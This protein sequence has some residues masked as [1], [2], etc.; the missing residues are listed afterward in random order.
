MRNHLW[1]G[2]LILGLSGCQSLKIL[3]TS[4]IEPASGNGERT[5]VIPMT[6]TIFKGTPSLF[7][8]LFGP[9]DEAYWAQACNLPLPHP[10]APVPAA[11]LIAA[12]NVVW[13]QAVDAANSKIDEIQERSVKSWTATWTGSKATI[14]RDQCLAIA[15]ISGGSEPKVEMA[16]MVRLT[17]AVSGNTNAPAFQWMPLGVWSRNSLAL[18]KQEGDSG[19]IGLSMSIAAKSFKNGEATA[20][21]S[22]PISMSGVPVSAQKNASLSYTPTGRSQTY[23]EPLQFFSTAEIST[24]YLKFA[25]VESGSLAGSN[26]KAKAEL[27]AW[28][29][30]LGPVATDAW[31]KKIEEKAAK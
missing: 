13:G 21:V 4:K 30:A 10:I 15:R 19:K 17:P 6:A 7:A 31:K 27:K 20:S 14:A 1:T 5:Q 22:D 16:V 8:Q 2:L 18:T 3:T 28:T 26:T 11:V 12:G 29:D 23:S 24:V 25:I 9:Q